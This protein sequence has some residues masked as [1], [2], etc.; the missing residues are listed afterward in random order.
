MALN[1]V[2]EEQQLGATEA[3]VAEG[4]E[5]S[6]REFAAAGQE[7]DAEALRPQVGAGL[8]W[9]GLSGETCRMIGFGPEAVWGLLRRTGGPWQVE[10]TITQNKA[11]LWL[12]ERAKVEIKPYA[13]A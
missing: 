1:R 11:L 3:E 12:R 7:F 8:S 10:E 5:D 13:K 2:A 9:V 4:L 6:R